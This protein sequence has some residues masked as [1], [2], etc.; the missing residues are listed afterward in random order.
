MSEYL[1]FIDDKFDEMCDRLEAFSNLNTHTYNLVG[2]DSAIYRLEKMFA[3][4]EPTESEQITLSAIDMVESDGNIKKQNHG[5]V[6]RLRKRQ[7]AKQKIL[8]CGHYDTVYPKEHDFQKVT[9]KDGKMMI[10]RLNH[11]LSR[12]HTNT[13]QIVPRSIARLL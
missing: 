9:R 7:D 1:K 3:E 2:L 11:L 4:L 12:S 5:R 8:L 13:P 6:L 10:N